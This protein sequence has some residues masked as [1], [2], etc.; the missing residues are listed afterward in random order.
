[1]TECDIVVVPSVTSQSGEMEGL[2]V[3]IMEAM[4]TGVPVV[5]TAHS[6]I[7]EILQDGITG[8]LTPE[9][10][11]VAIARAIETLLSEPNPALIDNARRLIE[12]TFN[13][14]VVAKQRFDYFTH[15]QAVA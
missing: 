8:H 11:P 6:G 12:Q 2:P 4:A 7:P 1:M 10:D 3:V 9:K 5:A 14:D 13:I 15:Y